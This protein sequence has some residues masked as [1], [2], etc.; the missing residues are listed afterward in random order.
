M[1]TALQSKAS[2]RTVVLLRPSDKKK[3][4]KLAE[5]EHVSSG[6]ILRRSLHAYEQNATLQE[7]DLGTMVAEM[8]RALDSALEAV[9]SA[10]VE[11]AENIANIRK[12]RASRS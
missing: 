3:L 12:I 1:A 4:Q 2:I 7:E 6:E 10:R 5:K 8:S 9:R 11:V